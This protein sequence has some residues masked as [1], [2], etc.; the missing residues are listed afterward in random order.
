MGRIR[1][2][3]RNDKEGKRTRWRPHSLSFQI[4][5]LQDFLKKKLGPRAT[6]ED[7]RKLFNV[8]PARAPCILSQSASEEDRAR[9]R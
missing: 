8:H 9:D 1:A 7:L 3:Q 4:Q 5:E 2:K 6:R